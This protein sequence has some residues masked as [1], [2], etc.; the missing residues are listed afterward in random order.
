ME[1]ETRDNSV[2][3]PE[4]SDCSVINFASR[5]PSSLVERRYGAQVRLVILRKPWLLVGYKE[6]EPVANFRV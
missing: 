1:S 3:H 5:R 2:A 4:R 6:L